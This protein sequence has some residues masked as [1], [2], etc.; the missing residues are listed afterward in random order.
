M[1]VTF[2]ELAHCK[3]K[4]LR[5]HYL[6]KQEDEALH[7]FNQTHDYDDG[8]RWNLATENRKRASARAF[9]SLASVAALLGLPQ[10]DIIVENIKRGSFLD[11]TFKRLCEIAKE[12]VS[13]ID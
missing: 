4:I 5:V 11:I 7:T 10:D 6:M 1:G 12:M 9:K 13:N 2:T 8:L 3:E